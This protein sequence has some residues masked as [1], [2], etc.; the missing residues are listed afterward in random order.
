MAWTAQILS[1]WKTEPCLQ[2]PQLLNEGF[3]KCSL[4][5]ISWE[6]VDQSLLA[7]GIQSRLTVQCCFD[8]FFLRVYRQHLKRYKL[9]QKASQ[10]LV[11]HLLLK[12]LCLCL[13]PLPLIPLC[14][15]QFLVLNNLQGSN[16]PIRG[17]TSSCYYS[18]LL[19][20]TMHLS[21]RI[22]SI[23]CYVLLA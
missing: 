2:S 10:L 8:I 11:Y 20:L 3:D 16:Y 12:A 4:A 6:H 13:L 14:R 15:L 19:D 5:L 17:P 9:S 23:R 18:F 21:L 22:T 7:G 1:C